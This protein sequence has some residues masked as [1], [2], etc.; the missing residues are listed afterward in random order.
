[1]RSGGRGGGDEDVVDRLV[2]RG[3]GD[4]FMNMR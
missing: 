1:M 4:L 2:E 3:K